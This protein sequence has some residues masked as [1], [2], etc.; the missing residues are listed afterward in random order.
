MKKPAQNTAPDWTKVSLAPSPG[1][2]KVGLRLDRDVFDWFRNQGPG[3]QTRINQVLR[4]YYEA[5]R[6]R[7]RRTST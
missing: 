7:P 1:K 3:H 6:G 5:M 4:A 2:L